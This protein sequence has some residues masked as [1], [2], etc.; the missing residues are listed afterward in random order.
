MLKTHAHADSDLGT[1]IN[2]R[3]VTGDPHSSFRA[4]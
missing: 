3:N 1:L 4:N 2:R